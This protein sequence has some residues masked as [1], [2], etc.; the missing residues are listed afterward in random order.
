MPSPVGR[1][2]VSSPGGFPGDLSSLE[3][4][5]ALDAD[6]GMIGWVET[7]GHMWTPENTLK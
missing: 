3:M 6:H 1:V 2:R 4:H 7:G 5:C